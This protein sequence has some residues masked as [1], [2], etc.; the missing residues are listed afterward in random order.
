MGSH[1][2]LTWILS[3]CSRV[4]NTAGCVQAMKVVSGI[5]AGQITV[6]RHVTSSGSS[7]GSQHRR[8]LWRFAGPAAHLHSPLGADFEVTR[9]MAV[10]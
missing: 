10:A 1:T 5:Q 9:D 7:N 8:N 3:R 6:L 2:S 4:T